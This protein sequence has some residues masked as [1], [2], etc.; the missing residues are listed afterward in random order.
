MTLIRIIEYSGVFLEEFSIT[1]LE[2][3]SILFKSQKCE[4]G[5]LYPNNEYNLNTL[6]TCTRRF[7]TFSVPVPLNIKCWV[8]FLVIILLL[9]IHT[10]MIICQIYDTIKHNLFVSCIFGCWSFIKKK[11]TT[12]TAV[13]W[14]WMQFIIHQLSK[15]IWYLHL[16]NCITLST[17]KTKD[18]RYIFTI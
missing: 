6:P 10:N 14:E 4:A 1:K 8:R 15:F 7:W 3:T 2:G 5:Y 11:L 9:N 13:H 17:L 16:W 18:T 12:F